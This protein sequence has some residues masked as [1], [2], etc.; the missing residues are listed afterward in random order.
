MSA[1]ALDMSRTCSVCLKGLS[2]SN[3]GIP[4]HGCSSKVHVKCSKVS[5]PKNSFHAYKG[6]W[7]CETCMKNKFPFHDLTDADF[8][9]T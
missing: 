8:G 2:K 5:D 7:Q 4:C 3:Q 9:F 6:N 1:I